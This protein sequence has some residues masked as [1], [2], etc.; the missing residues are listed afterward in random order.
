MNDGFGWNPE[1]AATNWRNHRVSFE[2]AIKAFR[3][4]FLIEAIDDREPTARSGST[5][6]ACVTA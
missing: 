2:Q 3:D 6:S 1:K 5:F 4:P